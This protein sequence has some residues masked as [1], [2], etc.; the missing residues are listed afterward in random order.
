MQHS[1]M[2]TRQEL[3]RYFASYVGMEGGNPRA[4]VW[5]CDRSPAW[6]EPIVAPLHPHLA[7]PAWDAV[8]RQQHRQDMARWFGH[9]CVARIMAAARAEALGVRLGDNDW[10]HYYWSHLYSPA[11]AEF[12]LSLFPLPAHVDGRTTWSKAFRGQPE[13][14]PQK[15]YVALCR[16]GERFR[17]IARTCERWRPKV[18]ICLSHRHTD[19]Y[20]EAFSLDDV[21]G[22]EHAL[23]PADQARR[24]HLF[25][26]GDTTWIIC[27]A[28]GG[29][30]GMTSQVQLDAFG[31]FIGAR[32]AASDFKHCLEL[33]AHEAP[34]RPE[35]VPEPYAAS[36]V[37]V[38]AAGR[39]PG[40]RIPPGFGWG[41]PVRAGN[42]ESFA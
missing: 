6:S 14:I 13:L 40:H 35:H 41:E 18:V 20:V 28:I 10:E 21:A 26:R 16:E 15:R 22:E 36:V 7:P 42:C 29:S 11:G 25:T 31:K 17:F 39:D 9:Q 1:R 19:E 5:I 8:F 2:F 23:R 30:A 34:A 32:L 24:L 38:A 3:D 33:A 12:R 27:P 4:A 37:P